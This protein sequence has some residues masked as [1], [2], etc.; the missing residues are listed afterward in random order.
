MK[1]RKVII[2]IEAE[3][4]LTLKELLTWKNG[5]VGDV[6]CSVFVDQI[7]VDVVKD[8]KPGGLRKA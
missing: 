1:P 7:H 8:S 5:V 6:E 4:E 2:T 3:T